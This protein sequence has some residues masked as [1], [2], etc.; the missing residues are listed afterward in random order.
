MQNTTTTQAG[1]RKSSSGLA[2]PEPLVKILPWLAEDG[3]WA[4]L[5][6]AAAGFM[7]V[8]LIAASTFGIVGLRQLAI[9]VLLPVVAIVAVLALRRRDVG[10]M[11]APMFATGIVATALYDVVRFSFLLT[12]LMH[13]DP[14]P[15]IG[16]ALHLSPAWVFGYLWR[17]LGNGSGLAL[18]FIALGFRGVRKGVLFGLFVSGGLITL[19]VVHPAAQVVLFP[20]T[21]PSVVMMVVGHA[22]FG[23]VV[24]TVTDR[25]ARRAG[26]SAAIAS[27]E[28]APVAAH[29]VELLAA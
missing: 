13:H 29:Q 28:P 22:V 10:R 4:R 17:Y 25:R 21:V 9:Q 26:P 6:L 23:G 27:I 16:T 2:F 18:A 7:P 14:I 1:S 19:L 11:V 24:G 5:F 12:H 3:W 8:T 15:H 20:I